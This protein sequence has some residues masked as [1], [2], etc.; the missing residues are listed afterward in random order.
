MQWNFNGGA[1][2]AALVV[3]KS[4]ANAG[5]IKDLGLIP[6]SGRSPGKG[7]GNP[8]QYSC[9]ENPMDRGVWWAAVHGVTKSRTRLKRLHT[10]GFLRE[11][12]KLEIY[13]SCSILITISALKL[14]KLRILVTYRSYKT[15]EFQFM[16]SWKSN[17]EADF[18]NCRLNLRV[19]LPWGKLTQLVKNPPAI[20]ET[21]VRSLGWEDPLEKGT[22]NHSS[23]LTWKIPWT[24]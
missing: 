13:D 4:P 14:Y 8:L 20:Q 16:T 23:I 18:L 11:T 7:N 21:W 10:H 24:V 2:Q 19:S 1:S 3:K 22:A 9:P 5:D 17:S 15:E 12:E 6:W